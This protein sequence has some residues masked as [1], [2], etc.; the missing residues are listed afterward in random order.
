MGQNAEDFQTLSAR[1]IDA[2]VVRCVRL[3]AYPA[4]AEVIASLHWQHDTQQQQS[5]DRAALDRHRQRSEAMEFS[6]AKAG[7]ALVSVCLAGRQGN[8]GIRVRRRLMKIA[9]ADRGI[10]NI[11]HH[12]SSMPFRSL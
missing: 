2:A 7:Q 1:G 9:V 5:Y 4:R 8:E 10:Y 12:P 11:H 6:T 3:A